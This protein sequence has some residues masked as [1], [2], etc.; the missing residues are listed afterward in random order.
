MT[1]NQTQQS[2]LRDVAERSGVSIRTASRVLNN[3]TKVAAKTRSLVQHAINELGYTPDLAAR[4][5]RA[6][7]DSTIGLLVESI[8]DPFFSELAE[9]VENVMTANGQSVFV[10]S[11]HRDPASERK[12]LGTLLQRRISGAI[13]TPTEGDHDWLSASAAP[14]VCIDRPSRGTDTDVVRINDS[15]AA[16]AAVEHLLAAG[17]HRIAYVGDLPTN[18]TSLDRQRAYEQTLRRSGIVPDPE[19]VHSACQTSDDAATATRRLMALQHPPTAIFSSATRCSLGVVPELHRLGRT[20]V[21]LIGFGDFAMA[22]TLSPAITVV[23]HSAATIGTI[24]AERLLARIADP[25]L[26]PTTIYV[27]TRIIARGSGELRP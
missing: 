12:I 7:T 8:A 14:I 3:D 26:T 21:A 18:T 15:E 5:L 20:G 11:T 9:A 25:E 24:A 19:L 27:P 13:I 4:S 22:D 6:G 2:T 16:S 23:E 10:S 17:H 1:P